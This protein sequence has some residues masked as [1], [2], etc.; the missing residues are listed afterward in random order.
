MPRAARGS[1]SR[2]SAGAPAPLAGALAAIAVAGVVGAAAGLATTAA[3]C[4]GSQLSETARQVRE[5]ARQAREAGAERCAPRELAL[6]DTNVEFAERE[7]DQGNYFRAR[8][9]LQI[10]EDNARAAK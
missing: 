3:G 8:D 7:V 10:A 1:T 9:H 4:A 5:I 6:A 2:P